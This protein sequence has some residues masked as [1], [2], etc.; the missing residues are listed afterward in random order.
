MEACACMDTPP[1]P[2]R[3]FPR[4]TYCGSCPARATCGPTAGICVFL[5]ATKPNAYRGPMDV[6][7]VPQH[8]RVQIMRLLQDRWGVD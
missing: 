1:M 2:P 5:D 3:S 8:R 7:I 4:P 6:C